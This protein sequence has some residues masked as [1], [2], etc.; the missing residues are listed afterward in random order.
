M[1]AKNREHNECI[2]MTLFA[3]WEEGIFAKNEQEIILT[4]KHS[5]KAGTFIYTEQWTEMRFHKFLSDQ[6]QNWISMFGTS[7]KEWTRDNFNG[8]AQLQSRHLLY[9]EQWTVMYFHNISYGEKL[10]TF[11]LE[12]IQELCGTNFIQFWI[13]NPLE[14]TKICRHFAFYL[15]FVIWPT[16]DFS[17]TALF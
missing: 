16:M 10:L 2:L 6:S 12:G 13:P 7:C 14:W 1:G 8:E 4:A 3:L 11:S 15:S 17:M 9:T 5:C